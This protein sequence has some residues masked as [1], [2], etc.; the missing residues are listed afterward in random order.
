LQCQYALTQ[1]LPKERSILDQ[2]VPK[3]SQPVPKDEGSVEGVKLL[4]TVKFVKKCLSAE[5]FLG[6]NPAACLIWASKGR[7]IKAQPL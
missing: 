1:P 2:P 4:M 7:K 5:S 6:G 3:G